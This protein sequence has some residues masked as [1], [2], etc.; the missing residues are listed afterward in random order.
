MIEVE[1]LNLHT[2]VCIF[3]TH[4]SSFEVLESHDG[5]ELKE[6]TKIIMDN[7][8]KYNCKMDFNSLKVTLLQFFQL[9]DKK[10]V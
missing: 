1:L 10:E 2:T 9:E 7:G 8:V 6:Y 3:I 5:N 4:I